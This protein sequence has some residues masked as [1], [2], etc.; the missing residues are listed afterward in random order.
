M[1]S[2]LLLPGEKNQP[3]TENNENQ[4]YI[5]D[6]ASV[7]NRIV[8][9]TN[10][11]CANLRYHRSCIS[12]AKLNIGSHYKEIFAVYKNRS[13]YLCCMCYDCRY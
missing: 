11:V 10:A 12:G 4:I 7:S 3:S 2:S 6:A 13:S 9:C 8:I 5:V 1:E